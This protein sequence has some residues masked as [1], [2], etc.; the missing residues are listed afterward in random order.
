MPEIEHIV[1]EYTAKLGDAGTVTLRYS[2]PPL[3]KLPDEQAKIVRELM[4]MF[5]EFN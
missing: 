2:G 5:E 4:K 1:T 3:S